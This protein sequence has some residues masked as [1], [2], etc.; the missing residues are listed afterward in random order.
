MERTLSILITG[1]NGQLG[2]EMITCGAEMP[3]TISAFTSRELDITQAEDVQ[4]I[5][6]DYQPD[7]IINCAAYTKVDLAEEERD[8]AYAVNTDGVKNL[9]A[10][11]TD[12]MMLIHYSTDYV[13]QSDMQ[14]PIREDHPT[15]PC[16]HYAHTKLLGDEAI[17]HSQRKAI[18]LRTSWVY[19]S[20]GH[21]FVKTM[22]RLAETK[23]QLRI[24][25]DQWGNPSYAKDIAI[26]TYDLIRHLRHADRSDDR[27]RQ[28]YHYSNTGPLSWAAFAEEIFTK[29]QLN[30]SVEPI[31]TSDYP[32]PAQRPQWS[33][34]DC[35]K[36][37]EQFHIEIRDWRDSLS[38]CIAELIE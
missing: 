11:M 21:N 12:D 37:Q 16:N 18:I 38:E 10:A 14:E 35:S 8:K 15:S 32:T 5:I 13:Y 25:S 1:A 20:F 19:S 27:W 26:T 36:I 30:V 29:A 2:K 28:V 17:L 7:V 34:L 9:L 33:V 24:V 6:A 3:Y 4:R 31:P 22:L 23:D